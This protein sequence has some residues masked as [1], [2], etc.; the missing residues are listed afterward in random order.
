MCWTVSS[1]VVTII[2][3]QCCSVYLLGFFEPQKIQVSGQRLSTCANLMHD[4]SLPS[5]HDCDAGAANDDNSTTTSTPC[6]LG[7]HS[8]EFVWHKGLLLEDGIEQGCF[9]LPA[10]SKVPLGPPDLLGIIIT[11]REI[12]AAM[13]CLHSTDILHGDLT[14]N[15]ILLTNHDQD[16][17]SFT[18]KVSLLHHTCVTLT[19]NMII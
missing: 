13:G 9:R 11:A 10:T 16:H 2:K 18:V 14:G 19:C 7:A 3:G 8:Y 1:F 15:N 17:R 4:Q 5:V 6:C 12:A